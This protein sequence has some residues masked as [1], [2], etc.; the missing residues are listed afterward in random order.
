MNT[1][2]AAFPDDAKLWV[3][4]FARPL[5]TEERARVEQELSAFVP[6]WNSHG[7]PVRGAFEVVSDRFLLIAGC[8]DG[9]VGGCSTDS[10]VRVMKQLRETGIDGF[11]RSLVFFRD[12]QKRVQSVKRDDFQAMVGA[13]QIDADTV[14]FDPTI[15]FVGD[16]RR[17]GFETTFARSWHASAFSPSPPR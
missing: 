6:S 8:V 1:L 14:V 15:Q 13:G 16:L 11:D 2:F 17:G 7:A 12:A 4:A 10:M 9:G 5:S 3:Y